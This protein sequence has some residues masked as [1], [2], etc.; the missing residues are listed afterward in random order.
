MDNGVPSTTRRPAVAP[1]HGLLG[2]SQRIRTTH[3]VKGRTM[4]AIPRTVARRA[5]IGI[6]VVSL[7]AGISA[8]SSGG[9]G[10]GGDAAQTVGYSA[11]FLTAQFEVVLQDNTTALLES[12]GFDLL[13]PTNADS[14][15]GK[16]ITDVRDLISQ[17]AK[18]L[19]V[20]AND[21][22]AIIPALDYAKQQSVPVV[23]ID[24]GP[25][26]GNVYAIVRADNVGMGEIA[27]KAMAEA[28]GEKGTVLSL[29]GAQ[30]SINGRERSDGFRECMKGYPDI[31]LIEEPTDWDAAKQAAALQTTLDAHPDLA[32]VFQQSDYALSATLNVL[33]QAGRDAKVGEPGHIFNISIDA[34]PQA[35]DL[36]RDGTLDAAISQPLD[37]YAKY[38]VQYLKD[39]LAGKELKLGPTDHN[40]EI[41]DFNGN[42]MDLLPATLVTKDNVDDKALWG[43]QAK[44]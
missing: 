13:A 44:G 19:I 24:I 39:A 3:P 12:E 32:G 21:S 1:R 26:G 4:S 42:K 31:D 17:G 15:S 18:G 22:K 7:A 14:D 16:Q 8:C 41:V 23:T 33:T 37:G 6:A 34:T 10:N 40:S 11:P 27:C 35:L 29:M 5:V 28:I 25:D 43:N 36:V 9:S 2:R 38:G 20:V 30:T